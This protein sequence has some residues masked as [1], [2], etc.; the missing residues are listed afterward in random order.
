MKRFERLS[1]PLFLIISGLCLNPLV[2]E[3]K[4]IDFSEIRSTNKD[5]LDIPLL[6]RR[7]I[8]LDE[9]SDKKLS[10]LNEVKNEPIKTLINNGLLSVVWEDQDQTFLIIDSYEFDAELLAE[11]NVD[12]V[13]E[14][15]L[16]TLASYTSCYHRRGPAGMTG[17]TGTTGVTGM[18]GATGAAGAT[19]L[20][21]ATGSTGATGLTGA[22]GTTGSTGNTGATGRTGATGATGSTGATGATGATGRTGATG[23]TGGI[24]ATGPTGTFSVNA[25][26]LTGNAGT[27]PPT[28]FLGTTDNQPLDI[29]VNNTAVTRFTAKGQIETLT[30]TQSVYV[31][32]GAG[33][34]NTGTNN[35]FIGFQAGLDNTTGSSNT[36]LGHLALTNNTTANSNTAVGA[37]ALATNTIGFNNNAF[38]I[39]ALLNNLSGDNNTAIGN[40]TLLSVTVE[41]GNVG[42]GTGAN[43]FATADNATAL[44]TSAQAFTQAVAVG[45]SATAAGASGT[46]LGSSASASGSRAIALGNNA[47]TNTAGN[48]DTISIGSTGA[49]FAGAIN[50]GTLGVATT[51]SIQG[52]Y[53][54][55]VD[56][57]NNHVLFVSSAGQLGIVLSS[58]KFKDNI[59]SLS[60]DISRKIYE[61]RVVQFTY[62]TDLTNKIQYGMIAEEMANVIPEFV[63]RDSNSDPLSIHYHLLVPLLVKELQQHQIQI[64]TYQSQFQTLTDRINLLENTI[65]NLQNR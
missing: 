38:G 15:S 39:N 28:N 54:V 19:G 22:T 26:L 34:A 52:A 35:T 56:P 16:D 3:S 1:I 18:T 5:L 36:A 21:G 31:G 62:K 48:N 46:A 57:I 63:V 30:T 47:G 49:P 11:Q 41:N 37:S 55:P 58:A 10:D 8:R 23:A 44:G 64:E 17:A 29:G 13:I 43:I 20:S 6:D 45:S 32:L 59:Y 40:S 24:G 14:D 4:N 65:R 12:K 42:L 9:L 53:N 60:G 27:N 7:I 51:A 50:I 61:M 33:A 25:W 2:A